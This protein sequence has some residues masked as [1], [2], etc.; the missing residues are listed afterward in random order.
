LTA[1]NVSDLISTVLI[2][3]LTKMTLIL[4]GKKML[5]PTVI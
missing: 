1:F 3:V 2:R 5:V 4:G